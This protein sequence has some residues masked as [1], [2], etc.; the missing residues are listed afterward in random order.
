MSFLDIVKKE[1]K[2]AK[3][4]KNKKNLNDKNCWRDLLQTC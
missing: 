3:I 2:N 1:E 4:N